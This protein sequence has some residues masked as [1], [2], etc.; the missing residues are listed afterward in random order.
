MKHLW[1]YWPIRKIKEKVKG[2]L[3]N[4]CII[5]T[6]GQETTKE[7]TVHKGHFIIKMSISFSDLDVTYGIIREGCTLY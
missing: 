5:N 3:D 1:A 4:K 6:A 2:I 7:K